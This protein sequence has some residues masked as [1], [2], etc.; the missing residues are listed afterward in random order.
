VNSEGASPRVSVIIPA[1]NHEKFIGE[2]IGSVL[3]QTYSDFELIVIDDGSTDGTGALAKSFKDSRL[4]CF[5]QKNK[6]TPR[7]INRGIKIARGEFI[8]ILDSDD[9]YHP[10]RLERFV[11]MMDE[12]P[13]CMCAASRVRPVDD[14][15]Q[16]LTTVSRHGSWVQW[17][18]EA[19][20]HVRKDNDFLVALLRYNFVVSTSNIF[21]RSRVFE[22]Q[23]PFNILLAYCHDYEF[24]IRI[25]SRYPFVLLEEELLDYRLHARNTIREN[26]FLK[27]LEVLYTLFHVVNVREI[28]ARRLPNERIAS[29]LFQELYNNPEINPH[30]FAVEYMEII[31]DKSRIIETLNQQVRERNAALDERDRRLSEADAW[32]RDL[33]KQAEEREK[34][35][36]ETDK[37]LCNWEENVER[38]TRE[39]EEKTVILQGI[40]SSRSWLW[41]TRYRSFRLWLVS[42]RDLWRGRLRKVL[43][44]ATQPIQSVRRKRH[45]N[46]QH[47][48]NSVDPYQVEVI[49]SLE[50]DRPVVVHALA[51]FMMGGSSR[52]VADLV[53]HLGHCYDHRVVT[54]YV[55]TPP[56]FTGFPVHVFPRSA[57]AIAA[58]LRD[59]RARM[60]HIH[61]WGDCDEPW[62]R[63]VFAAAR[64]H[65][66]FVIENIN[67]PVETYIDAVV[68]RY[69]YVSDYARHFTSLI[70][71]SSRIIYPGSNLDMF[72]REGVPIPDETIGM[73]Y[74][75]ERDKL[76]EDAIRVFIDVVT[77]RPGTRVI[78]VGGGSFLDSYR[79]Q[80]EREGL[81]DN[82]EFPGYVDYRDLPHYY[83]RFSLF[84]APV[85]KESFGQV[86]PFAMGIE[87]PV[88]GYN[89]GALPEILNGSECLGD[90]RDE[91]VRIIIDL[92]ND[93]EKRLAIGRRNRERARELFSI[94]AMIERYA[95]LYGEL[96][97]Q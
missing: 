56:A 78:I 20:T 51:N 23:K 80:V 16:L 22:E 4:R 41:L 87:I 89:V 95:Q 54:S 65:P 90:N 70:P 13:D 66:C 29:P 40:Y 88:V 84:V 37:L 79:W 64:K 8:A 2:A 17:Y 19:L 96:L 92:L 12:K 74:R 9:V 91:L 18:E 46:K 86:S 7:T 1:Y 77:E 57:D 83:R 53:E 15:G 47:G 50:K 62:Y 67:T 58:F 73:V 55:P 49:H 24:L 52:L 30:R 42:A 3:T 59:S 28:L 97:D 25:V 21:V 75:L 10:E 63:E 82:F 11:A 39:L 14:E 69:V 31:N 44:I 68:D 5:T 34:R 26:E 76:S 48:D 32:L 45:P 27:H 35:F 72:K 61:Y 71:E 94:E 93:R 33:Q 60:L 85:W 81:S 43:S 38:L 36:A 6:G